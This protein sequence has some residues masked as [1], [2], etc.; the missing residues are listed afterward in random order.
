[1]GKICEVCQKGAMALLKR[2]GVAALSCG[3]I[4]LSALQQLELFSARSARAKGSGDPAPVPLI[5]W[6]PYPLPAPGLRARTRDTHI[7]VR[8][9]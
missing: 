4:P 1:M 9:S 5:L 6:T 7:F 8:K 2:V 3:I